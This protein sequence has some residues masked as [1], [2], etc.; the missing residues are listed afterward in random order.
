MARI[1]IDVL[2]ICPTG[3]HVVVKLDRSDLH[4]AVSGISGSI[5]CGLRIK[6]D[7]AHLVASGYQLLYLVPDVGHVQVYQS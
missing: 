5:P 1:G 3:R 4:N 7:F 2:V 6:Y